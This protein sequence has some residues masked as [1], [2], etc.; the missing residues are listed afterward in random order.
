MLCPLF[1]SNAEKPSNASFALKASQPA[2]THFLVGSLSLSQEHTLLRYSH[3]Y[4][5]W[6]SC[7]KEGYKFYVAMGSGAQGSMVLPPHGYP[8]PTPSSPFPPTMAVCVVYAL[9]VNRLVGLA[10]IRLLELA[11]HKH[12]HKHKR[13][14][15]PHSPISPRCPPFFPGAFTNALP[16]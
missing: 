15:F 2:D 7:E 4:A 1:C 9:C 10:A 6:H 14:I 8:V 3:E 13:P 12:K 11:R 5:P 16:P